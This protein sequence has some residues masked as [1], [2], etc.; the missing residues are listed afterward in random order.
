MRGGGERLGMRDLPSLSPLDP[1]PPET[2]VST[3]SPLDRRLLAEL[4]RDA[5]TPVAELVERCGASRASVQ[6]RLR[7]LREDGTI[8]REVAIVDRAASDAPMTFIVLVE[9]ERESLD[10][11]DAFRARARKDPSV[12]QCY[13]VAGET[14]FIVIVAAADMAD[15]ERFTKRFFLNDANIRRFRTSVAVTVDKFDTAL[16]FDR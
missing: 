14:D 8:E 9:V 12:Q 15:Y 7:A 10:R 6:R 16:P 2:N 4:Q 13:C 1:E 3:L 5:R 11:L